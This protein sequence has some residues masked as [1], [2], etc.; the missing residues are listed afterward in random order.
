MLNA[1]GGILFGWLFWRRNLETAM[2]SHAAVHVA[3]FVM[4]AVLLISGG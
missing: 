4:N 3:F 1:A 2:V